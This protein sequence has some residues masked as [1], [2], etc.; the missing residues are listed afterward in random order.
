MPVDAR[1]ILTDRFGQPIQPKR[2]EVLEPELGSLRQ[3]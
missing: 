3:I 2:H 1:E